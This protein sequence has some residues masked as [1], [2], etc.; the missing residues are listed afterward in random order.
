M[1]AFSRQHDSPASCTDN[2]PAQPSMRGGRP[3]DFE[4]ACALP[5]SRTTCVVRHC[6]LYVCIYIL[7][8]LS[9][10]RSAP[11]LACI[12]PQT[13]ASWTAQS[14]KQHAWEGFRHG[15]QLHVT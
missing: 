4:L 8:R 10:I 3:L 1:L 6:A 11:T 13:P 5:P 12:C 7:S 14:D 2:A 9:E 15:M